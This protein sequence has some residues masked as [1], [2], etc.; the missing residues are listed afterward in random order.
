MKGNEETTWYARVMLALQ[1]KPLMDILDVKFINAEVKL[2][3]VSFKNNICIDITY[4]QIGGIATLCYLQ[5]M[6]ENIAS[7]Y[8]FKKSVILLKSWCYY[9]ARILGSHHALL[10]TY[11]ITTLL[12]CVFNLYRDE[13]ESP[14]QALYK[15]LSYFSKFDWEKY[16]V[17]I[18]GPIPK[19]EISKA[20]SIPKNHFFSGEFIQDCINRYGDTNEERSFFFKY[21]NIVDTLRHWNNL[22]RSVSFNSFL[23]IRRV[24]QKGFVEL[25]TLLNSNT[26]NIF[27]SFFPTIHKRFEEIEHQHSNH[28]YYEL[29]TSVVDRKLE[30]ALALINRQ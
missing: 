13:I 1:N 28:Q 12:I 16:A 10:S 14:I 7:N 26:Q 27:E 3:K 18:N 17:T 23:R 22:G 29:N 21:M 15:F 4:G 30:H 19:N 6:S 11:A 9:E 2:I 5:R 24:F 25:D 20:T 8:L